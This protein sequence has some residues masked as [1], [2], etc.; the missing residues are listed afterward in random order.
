MSDPQTTPLPWIRDDHG[1][2]T[3][4]LDDGRRYVVRG[5]DAAW[6]FELVNTHDVVMATGDVWPDPSGARAEAA[7]RERTHQ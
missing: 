5:G 1:Q 7:R 2:W 4:T 6:W 3:A